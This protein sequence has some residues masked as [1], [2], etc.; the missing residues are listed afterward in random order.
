MPAKCPQCGTPLPVGT[1]AGLCPACLLQAGAAAD[2]LSDAKQPAFSPPTVAELAA[3]F[4]QL[5]ILELIGKGG[6]GAVYKARQRQLDRFVAL[7]ILPPG[8]GD[9]P[10]FAERFAR[11]AKALAKLNHPGIV[12]IYDFGRADGLFYFF[13]EFVD[14]VNLRQLLHAGRVS[15]REALAIVPQICDALQFAHDQ[16]IVHRDIKPENILLDRRGRV[17]VAD[18]GLAKIMGGEPAGL[19]SGGP[20]IEN[21]NEPGL[22][23][24]LLTESGKIMGTPQY[25]APEQKEH[26][27]VVDHRA[28]I[29]ALGVVFYQM[30]TGELPG[31][32]I[33][34]PS[35]KVH[36]DVRLDEVVLRALE[37]KPELRYQ[38]ASVL[39]TQLETIADTNSGAAIPPTTFH[40][41]GYEYKSKRTWFGLP[42]IHVANGFDPEA[43]RARHAR[44]IV[45]I[46]GVATGWLAIGGRAYGGIAIGGIAVGGLT[47]GG[48]SAGVISIGGLSLA[49]ALALGWVAIAPVAIGAVVAGYVAIGTQAF[50][51]YIFDVSHHN[52]ERLRLLWQNSTIWLSWVMWT[53]AAMLGAFVFITNRAKRGNSAGATGAQPGV[54][55]PVNCLA[56]VEAWLALMDN[57]DYAQSWQTAAKSFKKAISQEEWVERLRETRNPLGPVS[58]RKLKTAGYF[59]WYF[60]VKFDTAY[61]GLKAAVETITFSREAD[62]QW[63]AIGYLILPAYAEQTQSRNKAW[64]ALFFCSLSGILG[65][66]T[67]WVWPNPSQILVW[68]IPGAAL[69]GM[70]NGITARGHRLGKLAIAIG[71]VCLGIWLVVAVAE[72]KW[73]QNIADFGQAE[74]T[75]QKTPEAVKEK[76]LGDGLRPIKPPVAKQSD[77]VQPDNAQVSGVPASEASFSVVAGTN[78]SPLSYQWVF[79]PATGT[80][81]NAS[82][83]EDR[84]N[85]N[86]GSAETNAEK[87]PAS[88]ETWSPT[89]A[90]GEKPDLQKI[91]EE[92]ND[93]MK[94]GQYEESLQRHIWYHNHE[95]EFGDSYQN[96]VRITSAIADWVELGRRYPRAKQ[97]LLEIRDQD[98]R[99]L[100]GGSGYADLFT[101]V[102]SINHELHDDDATYELY[103]TIRQQDPQLAGQGYFWIESL[104]VAKGEY[105][106]CYDHMGDPEFRF[107]T[108]RRTHEME[109]ANQKRMAE[110]Q[111]QTKQMIAAM[112]QKNGRTNA[113]SFSPPDTSAMLK[114][115]TEDRFVGQVRQLVEILVATDHKPEAEKIR[116]QAVAVL[117]DARLKSAVSD[118]EE[119]IQG[120]SEKTAANRPSVIYVSP[121][122]GATN[123][124]V[125]QDLRIRFD[126]PMKPGGLEMQWYGGGFVSDGQFSYDSNRNEFVIPVRL[127]PG[128]TNEV[129]FNFLG[130]FKSASGISAE[131]YHWQFTTRPPAP[132]TEAAGPKVVRISP[133]PSETMPVL[134][135]LDVTFDQPMRPPDQG[136]PFLEK[137]W[138]DAPPA[139]IPHFDYDPADRRFT[140]PLVLP[141][142]N[143]VKIALAGFYSADGVAAAP[144]VFRCDVGTNLYS[145]QLMKQMAT[146]A[147]DPQLEQLLSK[148]KTA[149]LRLTS[150][151][152]TV[153]N[154]FMFEGEAGFSG[155]TA[156]QSTF[157]WQGTNHFYADISDVMNTKAFILGSDGLTCW[158]Y[159]DMDS[160]G[161]RIESSPVALMADID[162]SIADP[163][164]L[165]AHTAQ[166]AMA[167]NGLAYDGLAQLAGRPCQRV[168]SWIVRQ[169]QGQSD[170]VFAAWSEWWIDAETDLPVQLVQY[171]TY[172]CE[173][174]RFNYEKLNE[175]VA[176]TVFR[177][178]VMTKSNGKTDG[179]KLFKTDTLAPGEKRFLK[180]GDGADGRMSGRLGYRDANDGTTSSGLN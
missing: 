14:G 178:P 142:D 127:R 80:P 43:G 63:R 3:K 40:G 102:N 76:K 131:K 77:R 11:E 136:F 53:V 144:V 29:Y 31:K 48:I 180:I 108:L 160:D 27:D 88:A 116:D 118:A 78:G 9:D 164:G 67:W 30:L 92:A 15:P 51:A 120:G 89:L 70:V 111:A 162:T 28:D 153:Q 13:M 166:S 46:G 75:V 109:L 143:P 6:M 146:A 113:P 125:V 133:A 117:D 110:T 26:P 150:G 135:L 171:A 64:E 122:N 94:R 79:N 96:V 21:P 57:G 158:L 56:N 19:Q 173:I 4:P 163:F 2:T 107:G 68:S 130:G 24:V 81:T 18:F 138:S 38:Q 98:T 105:Q 148:M 59:L 65:V 132:A 62:G 152:E 172:G 149:R 20:S 134:T 155:I 54:R 177:P 179:F 32:K 49:L 25:M 100:A 129:S 87:L 151:S 165:L 12:T 139:I 7:K 45:A 95:K 101:D 169:P 37:K 58:S 17:K 41:Q 123:V 1:L 86:P 50:G 145:G 115:S 104:L 97:A 168:K 156:N 147:K 154:V 99:A 47:I 71:S 161:Q 112:N 114:K 39:K 66:V 121:P 36:I 90:P 83:N 23:P 34:P 140:I 159:S 170:R 60:T 119:K 5:E 174:Y 103:K 73:M 35:S 167:D 84:Q 22:R 176:E 33:E 137:N 69:V 106:W 61:A 91:L 124:A 42:L 8:I 175:P 126:Q 74:G 82:T 44:G 85:Q 128:R 55:P 157:K 93:L 10:A 52:T 141:A 72:Q 16:G